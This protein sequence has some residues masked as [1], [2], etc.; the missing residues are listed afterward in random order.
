M[1]EAKERRPCVKIRKGAAKFGVGHFGWIE[2]VI[3]V[4]LDTRFNPPDQ[5]NKCKSKFVTC[6]P[7][8]I[9]SANGTL[10]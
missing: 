7:A 8:M 3:T 1:G 6:K 9:H 5:V 10:H 4:G 2:P